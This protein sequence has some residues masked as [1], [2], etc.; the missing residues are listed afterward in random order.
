MRRKTQSHQHIINKILVHRFIGF[1]EINF[2]KTT[3]STLI[4]TIMF[5][6]ILTQENIMNDTS[7]SNKSP[8]SIIIKTLRTSLSLEQMSF[9]MHLYKTRQQEIGLKSTERV[10]HCVLGVIV[11]EV[12]LH[13]LSSLPLTTKS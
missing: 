3:W 12:I 9:E 1:S 4:P 8:L 13:A 6:N 10:E 7:I 11:T 2:Q 5:D